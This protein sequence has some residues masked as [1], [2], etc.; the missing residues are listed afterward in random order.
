MKKKNKLKE[1]LFEKAKQTEVYKK[2]KELF[3]E[4]EL[5]EY[6]KLNKDDEE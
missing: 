4:A 2:V 1:E 3:P 5:I 6:K